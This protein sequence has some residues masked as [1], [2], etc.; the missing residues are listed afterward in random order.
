MNAKTATKL[1]L[2]C[3]TDI[4]A[5]YLNVDFIKSPGVDL[6]R[7]L[8][9]IPYPFKENQFKVIILRNILEHLDNP[10][11]VI[12][13]IHRISKPNAQIFLRVPHFS[14]NNVWGDLQHKRGFNTETFTR[15]N[16]SNLF[17]VINQKIVFG[18][19]KKFMQPITNLI[20]VFYERHLAYMLTAVDIIIELRV[21][22]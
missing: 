2:G 21:K 19:L 4:K 7:D 10:F 20:P 17:K 12:K 18:R 3:G 9:K 15:Y 6:V 14:S 1:N 8:N 22:K 5:G 16:T 11:L 13:E